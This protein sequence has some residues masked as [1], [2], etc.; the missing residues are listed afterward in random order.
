MGARLMAES[1]QVEL[2]MMFK[3]V[4]TMKTVD[5]ASGTPTLSVLLSMTREDNVVLRTAD[6]REFVLAEIDDFDREVELVRQN[7]ELMEFLDQRSRPMKTY[8]IDQARKIL[9]IE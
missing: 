9:E 8:T 6:G 7:Q 4:S 5:L 2:I 1:R 3:L